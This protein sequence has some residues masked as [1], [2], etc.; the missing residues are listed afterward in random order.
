MESVVLVRHGFAVSNRDGVASCAVP[1]GSLMP[2]G[3]AQ[4]KEPKSISFSSPSVTVGTSRPSSNKASVSRVRAS[5]LEM[6]SASQPRL[7]R[8]FLSP[9]TSIGVGSTPRKRSTRS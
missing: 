2:E 1:G 5:S 6:P 4:A 8:R 3:I 9:C 7:K